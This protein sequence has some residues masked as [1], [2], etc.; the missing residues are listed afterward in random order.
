MKYLFCL[1]CL[2][3]IGCNKSK[4]ESDNNVISEKLEI[5]KIPYKEFLMSINKKTAEEKKNY[6]FKFINYDVPNYWMS[7]PWS[8][9]GTSREPQKSTI[10]CGY[11]VTNTLTDFGFDINRTYLAQQ[12]SSVMIKKLCKNIKYFSS[13]ED[14]EKYILSENKNQVYIVGLD[15]HTGF[16]TRDNKDTYFI[17][18]NYIKNKAVVK[19]LTQ[20]SQ[21]LNASKTFMIGT[22]NY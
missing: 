16:I 10:A 13:R 9:N 20:A 7:T 3:I 6:L 22:L 15:F 8:F 1:L 12:A 18:S 11:F 19:E 17:H 21:A 2:I 5:K 14:L 4:V